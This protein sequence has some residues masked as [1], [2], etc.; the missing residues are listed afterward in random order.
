MLELKDVE[1][2]KNLP[3][4]VDDSPL[5][6]PDSVLPQYSQVRA[7]GGGVVHQHCVQEGLQPRARPQ[8]A[9]GQVPG[10]GQGLSVSCGDRPQCRVCGDGGCR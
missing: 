2:W 5:Y 7:H 6:S 10:R 8:E 1:F 4:N 9:A 3:V